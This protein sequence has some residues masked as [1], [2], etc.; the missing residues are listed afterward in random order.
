MDLGLARI[1]ALATA[2]LLAASAALAV[3]GLSASGRDLDALLMP[4]IACTVA[5]LCALV[6]WRWGVQFGDRALAVLVVVVTG[7]V[8]MTAAVGDVS[9][10][11]DVVLFLLPVVFAACFLPAR[12]AGY[13]LFACVAAYG[14]LLGRK[15]GGAGFVPWTSATLVLT[16]ACA[17][18]ALLR[19]ELMK[20]LVDLAGLARCDPLTGLLN[21]RS[22]DQA[23]DHEL[24]R[25]LRSGST[26]TILMCD[27]DHFKRINDAHGHATGDA[28]LARVAEDLLAGVRAIDT[29]ARIG[30]E[31]LAL[32][33]IDCAA[34]TAARVAERLRRRVARERDGSPAVTISIGIADSSLAMGAPEL[35]GHADRALYDA[36]RAGRNRVC[37]AQAPK[38]ELAA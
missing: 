31:E 33:L 14:W 29:V 5:V 11:S 25:S 24:E 7:L 6:T 9:P 19:H 10:R 21:R 17:T 28:V 27:L 15:L 23:L 30:G 13:T 4:L 34:P 26:C 36:K 32:L 2:I 22:F 18:V 20:T 12:L 8:T 3:A 35:L 1:R 37:C 16:S 38:L